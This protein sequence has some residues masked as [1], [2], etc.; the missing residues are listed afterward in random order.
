M[1][2][3]ELVIG[4]GDGKGRG[5]NDVAAYVVTKKTFRATSNVSRRLNRVMP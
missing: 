2:L 5:E 1:C 3:A 4:R